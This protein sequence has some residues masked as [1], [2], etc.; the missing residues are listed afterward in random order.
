MNVCFSGSLYS[1]T[2]FI[3]LYFS[4][5]PISWKINFD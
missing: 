4:V 1:A 5:R 2:A 3:T